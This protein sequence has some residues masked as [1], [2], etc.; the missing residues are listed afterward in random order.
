MNG[1][2]YMKYADERIA[3]LN[4]SLDLLSKIRFMIGCKAGFAP[5]VILNTIEVLQALLHMEL[6]TAELDK[7]QAQEIE[8]KYKSSTTS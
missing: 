6:R 2:P 7:A 3:K 1:Y 8:N 5:T 4:T